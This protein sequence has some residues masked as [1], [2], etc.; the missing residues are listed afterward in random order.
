MGHPNLVSL[1]DQ[2]FCTYPKISANQSDIRAA[3]D[4]RIRSSDVPSLTSLAFD[5]DAIKKEKHTLGI[6]YLLSK[7]L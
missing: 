6:W 4:T 7:W 1:E 2:E 5:T 3:A